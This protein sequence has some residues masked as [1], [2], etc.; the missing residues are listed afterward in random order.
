[1]SVVSTSKDFDTL[2]FTLVAEFDAPVERVWELWADP[3]KLERWWGPPGYPATFV[4]HELRAG[5]RASYYMTSPEGER[6]HGWWRISAVTPPTSLEFTDGFGNPD[7]SPNDELPVTSGLV[8]LAATA[9]GT[10]MEIHSTFQTREDMEK[11][12]AMGMAEGITLS[13][14]QMETLLAE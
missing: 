5:G 9:T 13:V 11:L 12:V 10:R 8:Q 14:G 7:G 6:Y 4:E 1:M 3:R 2:T